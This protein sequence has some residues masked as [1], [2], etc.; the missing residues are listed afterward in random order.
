[1]ELEEYFCLREKGFTFR[2]LMIMKYAFIYTPK[3]VTMKWW[4][5][6]NIGK[7]DIHLSPKCVSKL[8]WNQISP[9]LNESPSR[10]AIWQCLCWVV[11]FCPARPF[12]TLDPIWASGTE[13]FRQDNP[14]PFPQFLCGF[15][16]WEAG[17]SEDVEKAKL[18]HFCSRLLSR[19]STVLRFLH[20]SS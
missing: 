2:K 17:Q 6:T 9:F 1:M 19:W 7:V 12:S 14:V 15:G 3:V 8:L 4:L 10:A 5:K 13:L 20:P 16:Q 11:Y 18:R